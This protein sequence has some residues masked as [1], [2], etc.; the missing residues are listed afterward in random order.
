MRM[1]TNIKE[2]IEV[3]ANKTVNGEKFLASAIAN[4]PGA[5]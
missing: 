5:K 3:I 2:P 1:G 4:S